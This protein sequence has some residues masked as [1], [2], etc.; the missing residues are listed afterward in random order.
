MPTI[1]E[2]SSWIL[3]AEAAG[4]GGEGEAAKT[5]E[6]AAGGGGGLFGPCTSMLPAFLIIMVLF[7]F[8]MIRPQ[9]REQ[10]RMREMISNL[11]K[12]DRVV[13]AG[14]IFGTVVNAQKESP[15]VTIRIDDNA[16]LKVLRTSISR[17]VTD[18]ES[19]EKKDTDK[20]AL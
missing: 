4:E 9:K 5:G 12:S 16:K 17:V 6:G 10:N 11:K 13:T 1:Y 19:D 18:D 15:Y 2:L 3:A 20:D 8:M 14:G 7:Y